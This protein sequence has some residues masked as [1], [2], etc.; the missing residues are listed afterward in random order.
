[1]QGYYFSLGHGRMSLR[2]TCLQ[3]KVTNY[4]LK[5]FRKSDLTVYGKLSLSE[6]TSPN[7]FFSLQN[8]TSYM[9]TVNL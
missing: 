5:C 7:N 8:R 4:I 9:L 6:Y 2:I 1:M 3:G